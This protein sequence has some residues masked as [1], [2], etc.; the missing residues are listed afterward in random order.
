MSFNILIVDDS[1]T[2]RAMIRRII[3]LAGFEGNTC[4]EAG[5][6]AE[7]LETMRRDRVD[8]VLAD[9][10]MPVMDGVQMAHQMFADEK[11]RKIPVVI[12]SSDPNKDRIDELLR[13]GAKGYLPKPFTPEAFK[14]ALSAV[15]GASNA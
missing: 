7:A 1:S 3:Q 10:H 6:G 11:L 8:L 14:N 13:A 15:T 5:N 4:S 12:V 2:I 9:L